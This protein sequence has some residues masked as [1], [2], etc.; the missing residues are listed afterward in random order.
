VLIWVSLFR[1]ADPV[2][3]RA[4]F[5]ARPHPYD[6]GDF[7]VLPAWEGQVRDVLEYRLWTRVEGQYDVDLRIFFGRPEP[8][9]AMVASAQ[10]ALER[11]V[12]PDWDAWEL[13]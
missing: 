12:L 11:L 13:G 1:F 6:L 4:G 9:A 3:A 10:A 8:S 2:G 5:P 7:E